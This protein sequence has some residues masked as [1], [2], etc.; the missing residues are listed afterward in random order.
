M[1]AKILKWGLDLSG[2]KTVRIALLDQNNR[3]VTNPEDLN[4]AVNELYNRINKMGVAE[5]TI[6]IENS[7][8]VLDFPARKIFSIRSGQSFSDV[9]SYCQ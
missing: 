6:R 3:P 9:F 8:I 1:T 5:R 4:Q 7:N 2:G